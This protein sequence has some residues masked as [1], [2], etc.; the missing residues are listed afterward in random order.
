MYIVFL[1]QNEQTEQALAS[2][3][4]I[5]VQ[6]RPLAHGI[7]LESVELWV[8]YNLYLI[9]A[10]FGT[11]KVRRLNR[12]RNL[13]H[14]RCNIIYDFLFFILFLYRFTLHHQHCFAIVMSA[15]RYYTGDEPKI[16]PFYWTGANGTPKSTQI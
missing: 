10:R 5:F 4:V 6:C 9:C 11:C 8:K 7:W 2:F 15:V 13:G 16:L 14:P 1:K 3:P 12:I